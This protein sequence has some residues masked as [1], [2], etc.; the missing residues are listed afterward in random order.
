M[1]SILLDDLHSYLPAGTIWGPYFATVLYCLIVGSVA[2]VAALLPLAR[3]IQRE[4]PEHWTEVARQIY[5]IRKVGILDWFIIS[6]SL[7]IGIWNVGI[8]SPIGPV[9]GAIIGGLAGFVGNLVVRSWL[10]RRFFSLP[11][12]DSSFPFRFL[13]SAFVLYLPYI[14]LGGGA[15]LMPREWS[16]EVIGI[17][18]LAI[19]L[20]IVLLFGVNIWL[21]QRLSLLRPTR[22]LLAERVQELAKRR[23]V[24]LKG[25][26]VLPMRR[27]NAVAMPLSRKI[28]L[29]EGAVATLEEDDLVALAAHEMGHLGQPLSERA[30]LMLF[31]CVFGYLPLALLHPISGSWGISAVGA[32]V[33]LALLFLLVPAAFI[34]KRSRRR[35]E[36]ADAFA[37]DDLVFPGAFATA[38]EKVSRA[39]LMPVVLDSHSDSHPNTY[40]RL[41]TAGL[42]PAYPRPE[43]PPSRGITPELIGIAVWSMITVATVQGISAAFLPAD[44][45]EPIKD[46]VYV[47]FAVD[48]VGLGELGY[49][50]HQEGHIE[51]AFQLYRACA[52]VEASE[53]GDSADIACAGN[54]AMMA[55]TLQRCDDAERWIDEAERRAD[56][57]SAAGYEVSEYVNSVL[58]GAREVIDR[59]G[60]QSF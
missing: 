11:D 29:T 1:D 25:I 47:V 2:T 36:D 8:L 16:I 51:A 10:S 7:L 60:K 26:Y 18:G 46:A 12:V 54:A 23:G 14:L 35:E 6:V 31:A 48:H 58:F 42:Q 41:V 20:A 28:L 56:H 5:P 17:L 27:V 50:A 37:C 9:G 39:N 30:A 52:A 55:T 45:A 40:D 43:P 3:R 21:A 13:A 33:V 4:S 44:P 22:A 32:V 38:L 59:C 24:L 34:S 15:I 57:R 49:S 53:Y 19:S